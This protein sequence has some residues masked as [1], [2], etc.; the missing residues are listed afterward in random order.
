MR[1]ADRPSSTASVARHVST[2]RVSN[3]RDAETF[4]ASG[5]TPLEFRPSSHKTIDLTIEAGR[6]QALH[7]WATRS[8]SGFVTVPFVD[9]AVFS[10]RFVT[11]GHLVRHNASHEIVALP[12]LGLLQD[13]DPMRREE[14]SPQFEAIAATVDRPTLSEHF[15]ALE[16][17][18]GGALPDFA[19]IAETTIPGVRAFMLS[20][21]STH[22]RFRAADAP[23]DTLMSPLFHEIML[24]Q[25]LGA[26][27]RQQ[28]PAAAAPPAPSRKLR[29]ALDYIEANLA[30]RL[31]LADV[32]EACGLSVRTL[33]SLFKRELG[34][35]VV[36]I[37]IEKRLDRVHADLLVEGNTGA[38]VSQIAYRWGFA[39]MSD[40]SRRY[41]ERFGHLPSHLRQRAH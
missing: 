30:A 29:L 16:G 40:F 18:E 17:G 22:A 8:S 24:Y 37:V 38:L 39:H 15:R 21:L 25:F 11:R 26:W 33:Q 6:S 3:L 34:T 35:S 41:R 10:I 13:F 27:P 23:P 12:G 31:R 5:F 1:V 2:H 14:A 20:L 9:M 7:I 4:S 28:R 36:Q 19:P 32:A